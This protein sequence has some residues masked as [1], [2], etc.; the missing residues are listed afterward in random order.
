[1]DKVDRKILKELKKN[2]RLSFKGLGKRA[3]VSDKTA[4][5]RTLAMER[6]GIIRR[7]T[8]DVDYS[9]IK[10][11]F[12][13]VGIMVKD[14]DSRS[15]ACE[16]ISEFKDGISYLFETSKIFDV[17]LLVVCSNLDNFLM[18]MDQVRRLEEVRQVDYAFIIREWE[19]SE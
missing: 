8:I 12:A 5:S 17:T 11:V 10:K 16:K 15:K 4:A 13:L 7:Y 19:K 14:L 1:M 9:K 2:A 18:L 3:G 6:E